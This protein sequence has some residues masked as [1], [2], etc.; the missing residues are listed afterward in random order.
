M[1]P[2]N[3]KLIVSAAL[4]VAVI[5]GIGALAQQKNLGFSDTPILPG[6]KWHVHDGERP[7]PTVIDA[8]TASTQDAPGR[9]PADAVVLFDGKD[10]ANWQDAKGQPSKWKVEGGAMVVAPGGGQ[11]ISK[12]EFGDCQLHVEWASPTEIKG[13][14][15][16]RG[17]SGVFLFNRYEIQ[18]LDSYDNPSYADGQASA[19]YGQFPP[20]VNATRKP[21]EWQT[22]DIIFTGPRFKGDEVETPAYATVLHNGVV[23]HN[24]VK[25]L[26]PMAYRQL[27]KYTPH[28]PKGP[29]S[30]QDHGNPVRFRNVWVRELKDYDQ[31]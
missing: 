27:P 28:G 29:I 11:I 14:S 6:G 19:I 9:P 21:G 3:S 30:F 12:Q 16:G 25:L 18:V 2:T 23:V 24:H 7:L 13:S 17:N 22:Y 8:G 20:L 5:L 4:S 31:P 10:L 1:Q 15:Q 26:G